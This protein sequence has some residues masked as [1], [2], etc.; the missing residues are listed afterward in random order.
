MGRDCHPVDVWQNR[1][2]NIFIAKVL[3][4]P[5]TTTRRSFSFALI[6][7]DAEGGVEG[8]YPSDIYSGSESH[9]VDYTLGKFP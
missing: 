4:L 3:L 9:S 1:L 7:S 8:E 2:L 5:S 6:L